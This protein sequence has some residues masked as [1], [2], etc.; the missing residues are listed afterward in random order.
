MENIFP[1]AARVDLY[2]YM[3]TRGYKPVRENSRKAYYLSPKRNESNP[4]FEVDKINNRWSDR[5]ESGAYGS[6]IDFVVWMDECSL[7]EA[8]QK[9]VGDGELKQYHKPDII[10]VDQKAIEVVEVRD[11]ISNET[12]I[13][14]C[15]KIRKVPIKVVNEYCSEVTFQF[16]TRRYMR[17]IG[18]GL[19]N[20][21]GGWSI[22]NTWAKMNTRPSYISTVNF[23]E[24][25]EC[26]LF[27]GFFDWLSY[28]VLYGVPPHTAVI[29]NSLIFITMIV[30]YLQGLDKVHLWIDNDSPADDQVEYLLSHNVEVEDH[31]F[32]FD[33]YKDLNERLQAES[34]I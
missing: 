12:L 19:K 32:E 23:T 17:H 30:D 18:I 7:L 2:N 15:E 24:T 13:T 5:G 28:V 14:Y 33:P 20:D 26:L 31:R 9:I 22:R 29:L 25:P 21:S 11:L 27:E 8:A 1:I 16:A 4:S 6:I 34:S 10:D 3:S